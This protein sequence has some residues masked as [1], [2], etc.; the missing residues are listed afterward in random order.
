MNEDFIP[1]AKPDLSGNEMKYVTNCI[2]TNWISSQGEYVE[3]FEKNFSDYCD[4]TH[5]IATSNGTVSLHLALKALGIGKGDEVIVPN[6]TF[7][8]TVNTILHSNAI[9]VPIDIDKN[10]WNLDPEKIIENINEKTKAIM[11]VHIYGQPCEI[12]RIVEIAEDNGLFVIEDCA[13]AHGAE[14]SGK[15]VG[16]FGDI[17][18][19]SF[20]GNKIITTGE[21]GICLTDNNDLKNKME[22]LRDHGMSPNKR[23]WHEEIGYNYRM[24]NIQAAVGVAQLERIDSFLEK[25][26]DIY[27]LYTKELKNIKGIE[28]QYDFK[29]R[30][31]VNWMYSILINEN[32]FGKSRDEVRE[33]LKQNKIDS[34]P[35]FYPINKMSLYDEFTNGKKY[36]NS[37]IIGR[38]GISLPTFTQMKTQDV[39]RITKTLE[40][41][42][43][44]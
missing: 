6:F 8:A 33:I 43:D 21:G 40:K 36:P 1:M 20:Y 41:I 14:F 28:T 13:E 18:S 11:P 34:R 42:T 19:F 24:T 27:D 25:R 29:N 31:K 15:R 5:G 35:F 37:E 26:N 10:S 3:R 30:K 12:D 4:V 17:S 44:I 38:K 22:K 39:K 16:S 32:E 9:P 7:A 2:K 23:Y